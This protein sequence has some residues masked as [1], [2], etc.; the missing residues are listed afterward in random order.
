VPAL[1]AHPANADL[2]AW[3]AQGAQRAAQPGVGYQL[4][5][6]YLR[7]HPDLEETFRAIAQ[8]AHV[9]GIRG[10]FG[11]PVLATK[12]GLIYALARGTSGIG[13]R[14]PPDARAEALTAGAKPWPEAGPEWT[15]LSAWDSNLPG[16]ELVARLAAWCRRA[17]DAALAEGPA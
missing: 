14:L 8:A 10:A 5:G 13:L 2:L 6:W 3:L 15:L 11:T 17:H 4:D 7:A 16:R 1:E 12:T 9:K